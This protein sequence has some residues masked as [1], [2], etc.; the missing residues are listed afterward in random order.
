[1][2]VTALLLQLVPP[3]GNFHAGKDAR[4]ATVRFNTGHGKKNGRINHCYFPLLPFAVE[5]SRSTKMHPHY[6]HRGQQKETANHSYLKPDFQII[7]NTS[8]V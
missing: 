1:M 2:I 4:H 8:S 6:P 7:H 3:S 5:A